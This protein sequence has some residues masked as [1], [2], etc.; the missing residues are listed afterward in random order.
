M[1]WRDQLS[2]WAVSVGFAAMLM[3]D[4]DEFGA[5]D[6]GEEPGT[7]EGSVRAGQQ[8]DENIKTTHL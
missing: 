7:R 3:E 4:L 8:G 2:G 5:G 6:E 1:S